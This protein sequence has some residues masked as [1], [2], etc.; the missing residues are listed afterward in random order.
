MNP[1]IFPV[2]GTRRIGEGRQ[3]P[4]VANK[5]G[6]AVPHNTYLAVSCILLSDY[7]LSM[8]RRRHKLSKKAGLPPGTLEVT[9]EPKGGPVRITL[10][11]YDSVHFEERQVQKIEDCLPYRDTA[12]VTW[13]NIDGVAN[14]EVLE[15]IG[16]YFSIHPLILED[17]QNTE[18]RPKMEDLDTYLYINL[19][20]IQAPLPG[21]EIRLEHV[22]LI[23][24]PNYL[25]SFQEDPGDVFDPVR[26]RIR[27]DGR[28]RRFGPDYLA[29]A[30]IDNIVDNYFLVMERMEERVEDLEEELVENATPQSMEKINGLKKDMIYLRKAV[31]PLRELVTGLERSDSPLI[32][33]E[34][35][36]YLRDV[37][38]HIIQIIDTLE[39]YRD[40]VS[41]MIDIYLSG[42]SYKMN[43]IM[44]VLTLIATIFIPLTFIVGVYGMNFRNMPEI[45]YRYGYYVI[46]G[47][48]IGMVAIMLG[49]FRKKKWI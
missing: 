14:V 36:I 42:L 49:Y 19:K 31:W 41:G 1:V 38:D 39:T 17:I 30:L 40:M 32:K 27:K 2:Q 24:G 23:I 20:M 13:I 22:S 43:E 11:D 10:F 9:G 46:W 45:N 33:E 5:A 29:Y 4:V 18:Q 7:G 12:T 35:L 47:V 37:Y 34:T 26:E 48:M 25:L 8:S 28:I 6:G 3:N 44:K 16:T 21:K 15:K